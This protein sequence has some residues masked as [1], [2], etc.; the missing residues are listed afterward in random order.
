MS[1]PDAPSSPAS[2]SSSGS[3]APP[4]GA[5]GP[6]PEV[7]D[8]DDPPAT[9]LANLFKQKASPIRFFIVIAIWAIGVLIVAYDTRQ[10]T[11]PAPAAPEQTAPSSSTK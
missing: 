10:R 8:D 6:A 5:G 9:T 2:P 1:A 7:V 3:H 11:Q 4:A